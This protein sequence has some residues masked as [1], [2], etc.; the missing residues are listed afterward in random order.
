MDA[1]RAAPA[2]A[3]PRTLDL[4]PLDRIPPGE[5]R[6]Y[7]LGHRRVAVY[8]TRSG[9]LHATQAECPHRNGPL[10]DGLLDAGQVVCPL[11]GRRFDLATGAAVGSDCPPL[12]TYRVSAGPGG[13]LLL[14]VDDP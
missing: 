12:A 13:E 4:G 2:S 3:A 10:A 5:G 9:G 1:A 6:V 11:H 8:R 14:T 7:Q